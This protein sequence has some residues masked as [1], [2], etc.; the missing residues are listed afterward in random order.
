LF[1]NLKLRSEI[2]E[3]TTTLSHQTTTLLCRHSRAAAIKH[4]VVKREEKATFAAITP[5]RSE[6]ILIIDDG[7]RTIN[8]GY[9]PMM[10]V[11]VVLRLT[12]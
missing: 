10:Y 1:V 11:S 7:R 3:L 2:K 12:R 9:F 6:R 8:L 5:R 4:V